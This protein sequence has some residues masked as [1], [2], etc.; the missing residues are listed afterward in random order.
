MLSIYQE[1]LYT[2]IYKYVYILHLL[3]YLL[4]E[5]PDKHSASRH[6]ERFAVAT[7]WKKLTQNRKLTI[8]GGGGKEQGEKDIPIQRALN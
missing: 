8:Q 2:Y 3:L 7:S 6:Q 4:Y 1:H 5:G